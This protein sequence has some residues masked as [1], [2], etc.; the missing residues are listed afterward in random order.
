MRTKN[1]FVE[2]KK[3]EREREWIKNVQGDV[4]WRGEG[5]N[6]IQ[7]ITWLID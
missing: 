3:N 2:E 4:C 5:R 1:S 7:Y 6:M